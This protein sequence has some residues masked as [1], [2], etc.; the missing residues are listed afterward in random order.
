MDYTFSRHAHEQLTKS[1]RSHIKKEWIEMT[2]NYPDYIERHDNL[3]KVYHWK[4]IPE[5]GNR[6]LKVIYNPNKNPVNII[7][8]HFDRKFQK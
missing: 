6:A 1:G 8:V 7:T 4:R 2:L 3:N 5:Y